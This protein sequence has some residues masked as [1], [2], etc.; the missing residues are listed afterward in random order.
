M[1]AGVPCDKNLSFHDF[2]LIIQKLPNESLFKPKSFKLVFMFFVRWT[3]LV[4]IVSDLNKNFILLKY[5]RVIDN[6]NQS[7]WLRDKDSSS[8]FEALPRTK[9]Q[10]MERATEQGL[11]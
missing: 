9:L 3:H 4:I 6:S 5:A 7:T 10:C 1:G 2:G 11:G 8:S